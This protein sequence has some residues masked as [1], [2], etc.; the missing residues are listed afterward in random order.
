[1]KADALM[2]FF[3]HIPFPE[4]LDDDTWAMK[5]AQIKWLSEKGFLG[6]KLNKE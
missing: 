3:L 2:S 4:Q 5:W 1:M 6:F